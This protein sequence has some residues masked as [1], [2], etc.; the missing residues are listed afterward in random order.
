MGPTL[1]ILALLLASPSVH[2]QTEVEQIIQIR[3]WYA[4]VESNLEQCQVV[5]MNDYTDPDIYE[6]YL[7]EI[8]AWYDKEN[9]NFIKIQHMGLADW[10][11]KTS[12]CYLNNGTLFFIYTTGYSPD[13]M[14][15]AEEL[16]LTEEELWEMGGE[17][18]TIDYYE[19]RIYFVNKEIIRHLTKH[20]SFPESESDH[21]LSEVK[22]EKVAID[23]GDG[24]KEVAYIARIIEALNNKL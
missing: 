21:D 10:H 9:K 4:E 12:Y 22:N 2:A 18:K 24:D 19:A 11:E 14:Y 16:N 15:T 6:G 23:E 20:K 17:V 1:I 5:T 3:K 8:K 7:P 13:K